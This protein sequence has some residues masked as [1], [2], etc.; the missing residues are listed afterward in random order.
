MEVPIRA[1]DL[2]PRA[3]QSAVFFQLNPDSYT[4]FFTGF[5]ALKIPRRGHK[6]IDTILREDGLG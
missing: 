3:N 5:F 2:R 1:F 4:D 6:G